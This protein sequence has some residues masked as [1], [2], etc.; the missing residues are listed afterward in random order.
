VYNEFASGQPD[1]TALRDFARLLTNQ[2]PDKLKYLLLFGDATFDYKNYSKLLT[3]AQLAATLPTYESRES[4]HPVLSYSSD[5]YFGF[6]E[7][8][9][10][11]WTE[12]FSGDHSLDIGV[13]RLPAKSVEE[14]RTMVD[15]LIRYAATGK[16]PG[17]WA[18][19]NF[20]CGRRWRPR[21]SEHSPNR[22]RPAGSE[23]NDVATTLPD[24]KTV[25]G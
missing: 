11:E 24:R 12:D 18:D 15:K 7:T 20:L 2:T 13:G 21:F 3:P 14:A 19:E 9:E 23:N 6:L 25:S 17:D 16:L 22:C 8:A 1:P 4:L 5:D 10:G